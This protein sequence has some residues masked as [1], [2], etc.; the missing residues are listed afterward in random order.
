MVEVYLAEQVIPQ[1][2]DGKIDVYYAILKE[3]GG[4]EI[5][6]AHASATFWTAVLTN[7]NLC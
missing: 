1:F 4:A 3:F 5:A 7:K 2:K 6:N